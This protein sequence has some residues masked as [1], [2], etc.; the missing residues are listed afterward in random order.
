MLSAVQLARLAPLI[1]LASACGR[2][3]FEDVG[4]QIRGVGSLTDAGGN[5]AG[6]GTTAPGSDGGYDLADGNGGGSTS[7]DN[8]G[9]STGGANAGGSRGDA[10]VNPMLDGG[11]TDA[12]VAL[13]TVRDYVTSTIAAGLDQ[14]CAV[15]AGGNAACWGYDANG[16]RGDG[17]GQTDSQASPSALRQQSSGLLAGVDTGFAYVCGL[18]RDGSAWCWGENFY[19]QLGNPGATPRA[20]EPVKVGGGLTFDGLSVGAYHACAIDGSAVAWCWGRAAR[21]RL[22]N[23]GG[24]ADQNLPVLVSGARRF[25]AI[26]AGDSHSCAVE[27]TSN[28]LYCWGDGGSGRLGTGNTTQQ[29]VPTAVA[30]TL[31]YRSVDTGTTFTCALTVDDRALCWGTGNKGELGNGAQNGSTVPVEVDGALRFR[32]LTV[33]GEASKGFAPS[34][35]AC[36][37]TPTGSAYC[38]GSNEYGQL[39]TGNAGLA[40]SSVPTAVDQS[41]SGAFVAIAAGFGFTCA[42]D[43][44]DGA[45]CWGFDGTGELGTGAGRQDSQVPLRVLLP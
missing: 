23:G 3:G 4:S 10:R 34:P 19:G 2:F 17:T 1:L 24:A 37:L 11:G 20:E 16:E 25:V 31:D 5:E 21:G 40:L 26:S 32:T 39:G 33:S 9:G 22:G 14:G 38:W 15:R 43:E 42:I 6:N 44:A 18:S 27:Q 13:S 35:H 30:S 7:G 8:T 12:S 29:D 28:A 36:A 41:S 45:W